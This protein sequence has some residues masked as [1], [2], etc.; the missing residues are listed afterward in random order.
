MLSS[1]LASRRHVAIGAIVVALAGVPATLRALD[2]ER[3]LVRSTLAAYRDTLDLTQ[4]RFRAGEVTELDVARAATEVAA[5]ES[6]ALALD[7]RRAELE[8]A[9]AVLVGETSS[10][11][12]VA[13]AAWT[14]ALPLIPFEVPSTV[15]RRRPDVSAA[16]VRSG[17]YLATVGL[18]R[19]LGGGWDAST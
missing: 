5:T 17:Q 13:V 18:V 9:L 3:S 1:F 2:G 19:A 8:H 15:L 11:F 16:Q 4:R 7:R 10:S 12:D 6:E 14:T